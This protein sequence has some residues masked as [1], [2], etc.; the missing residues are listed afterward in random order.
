MG[1]EK[2][3]ATAR[4]NRARQ[5]ARMGLAIAHGEEVLARQDFESA[6]RRV[7][8]RAREWE[9]Q[10]QAKPRAECASRLLA[11]IEA[12]GTAEA[13]WRNARKHLRESELNWLRHPDEEEQ[14]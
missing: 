8:L 3:V 10:V 14:A 12:M 7:L 13:L 5:E 2:A 11:A 6:Q 4:K 1:N 9:A